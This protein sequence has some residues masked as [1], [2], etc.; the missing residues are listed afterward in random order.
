MRDY[1]I[2]SRQFYV[3]FLMLFLRRFEGFANQKVL[4]LWICITILIYNFAGLFN[5]AIY[6][7]RALK[8]YVGIR[9]VLSGDASG[10]YV[11]LPSLFVYGFD[12][13]R[14]PDSIDV[15]IGNGFN[16]L[17]NGK[18]ATKYPHGTALCISPFFLTSKM[19]DE[20]DSGFSPLSHLSVRIAGVFYACLGMLFAFLLLA[21]YAHPFLALLCVGFM[22]YG[23]NIYYYT[24][25]CP[26]YSHIFSFG[27][28]TTLFYFLCDSSYFLKFRYCLLVIILLSLIV[29]VRP[30]NAAFLFILLFFNFESLKTIAATLLSSKGWKKVGLIFLFLVI[31]VLP[32]VLYNTYLTGTIYSEYYPGEPF[33]N[34]NKPRIDIVLLSANN[35]LFFYT[36]IFLIILFSM[37]VYANSHLKKGIIL[38]ALFSAIAVVYGAWWI[39][40]LGC[41]FSHRAFVD[42]TAVFMLPFVIVLGNWQKSSR[43]GSILAI[44]L[45]AL[46]SCYYTQQLLKFWWYCFYGANDYDYNKTFTDLINSLK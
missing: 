10:Y 8:E 46:L 1:N 18:V 39:P 33:L 20:D 2:H 17:N 12:S 9:N 29:A 23:T 26:G 42:F 43:Y 27:L 16:L 21:K 7:H 5:S 30:I 38:I 6:T 19:F 15:K 44:A 13:K 40:S 22:F 31:T 41:G 14:F 4:L 11:Y 34:I 36:P 28:I 3:S 25:V 32:R 24:L 35:G 45:L 37:F